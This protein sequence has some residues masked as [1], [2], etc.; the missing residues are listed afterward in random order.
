MHAQTRT[1]VYV[2]MHPP[3][4][5]AQASARTTARGPATASHGARLTERQ[6]CLT[7]TRTE[8]CL[9]LNIQRAPQPRPD[10]PQAG[11]VQLESKTRLRAQAQQARLHRRRVMVLRHESDALAVHSRKLSE[12]PRLLAPPP[13]LPCQHRPQR[14]PPDQEACAEGVLLRAPPV[15]PRHPRP[16]RPHGPPRALDSGAP[17]KAEAGQARRALT[18]PARDGRPEEQGLSDEEARAVSLQCECQLLRARGRERAP[19]A[20]EVARQPPQALRQQLVA[21]RAHLRLRLALAGLVQPAARG[22]PQASCVA[23]R[24][25]K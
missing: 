22:A 4:I 20:E 7:R 18:A 15:L 11:P 2:C 6:R 12:R 23:S 3:H 17:A 10:Q 8:A 14:T 1:A 21:P 24:C 5:H 16:P 19:V 9:T 25:L 13:P